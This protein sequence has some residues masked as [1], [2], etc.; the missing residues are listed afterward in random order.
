MVSEET[1]LAFAAGSLESVWALELLLVLKRKSERPWSRE[2]LI[3][4]LRGSQSVVRA[5]LDNLA[6]AALLVEDEGG[7][8]RFQAASKQMNELVE[9]LESLYALKP[10]TVIRAIMIPEN[11]KLQILSDAFKIIE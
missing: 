6:R 10:A 11:K 8:F 3:R 2:D 1:V 5:S 9:E 4:E 7:R